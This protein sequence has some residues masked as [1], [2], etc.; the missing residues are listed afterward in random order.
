MLHKIC[1]FYM[2]LSLFSNAKWLNVRAIDFCLSVSMIQLQPW[3]VGY[4][5]GKF[6]DKIFL[7]DEVL[8]MAGWLIPHGSVELEGSSVAGVWI[9]VGIDVAESTIKL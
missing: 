1:Y 9:V 8:K 6:G 7:G 4:V 5:C 2:Q 3:F